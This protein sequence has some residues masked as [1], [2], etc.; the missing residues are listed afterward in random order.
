MVLDTPLRD[1]A[2]FRVILRCANSLSQIPT[3]TRLLH[4]SPVAAKS[5]TD[6]VSEAAD[7]VSKRMGKGL[8]SAIEAG[9]KAAQTAKDS[10]GSVA[11][12]TKSKTED[13]KK[14]TKQTANKLADDARQAK[15]DVEHEMRKILI[16]GATGPS[17]ILLVRKCLDLYSDVQL[18][19][20]VRS[21][22][23][24]PRDIVEN[25]A[26]LVVE[27]V[28][29][30]VELMT[31][32]MEG[33]QVVLSALGPTGPI[34]PSDTPLARGYANIISI[35]QQLNVHRLICLGTPSIRDPNDRFSLKFELLIRGI[36]VLAHN[37][38]KDIIAIGNTI[39]SSD[40]DW[41]IVRVPILTNDPSTDV[42]A[43]YVGDGEGTAYLSRAGFA[44][45][46]VEEAGKGEWIR[47]AP[48]VS[49]K[50]GKAGH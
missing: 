20:Y 11:Q 28:L 14:N 4:S 17:G 2:M 5:V 50:G 46:V 43:G 40:I 41:T 22:G 33:A 37:A 29:S 44:S 36:N 9:E 32:A 19:L 10:M 49:S 45:F 27:G 13:M 24:L 47:K 38:Y 23:K 21:P 1:L 48:F 25:S 3:P 35:M 16:F 39:W 8:A 26:V 12:E 18:V 42:V 31:K 30:N 7:K 34:Y 15:S 6:K